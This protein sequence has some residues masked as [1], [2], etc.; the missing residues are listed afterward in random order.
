MPGVMRGRR[1]AP[2]RFR[3]SYGSSVVVD[4]HGDVLARARAFE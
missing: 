1:R 3:A 2:A 4:E